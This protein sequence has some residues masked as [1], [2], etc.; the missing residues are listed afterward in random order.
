MEEMSVSTKQLQENWASMRRILTIRNEREYDRAIKRLNTLLDEVGTNERHPLYGLL[1]TL[2]TLVHAYEEEHFEE[3]EP[4]G[5]EM[6]RFFM[7][8]HGLTQADLPELGSRRVVS[9]ILRGERE[10]NARQIRA[11]AARFHVSPAVFV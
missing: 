10:L 6:L 5:P 2:G 7:E 4:S 1:D 9:E 3:P 11:L 8:E